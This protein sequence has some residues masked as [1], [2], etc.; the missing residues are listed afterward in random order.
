MAL[1]IPNE[2][3]WLDPSEEPYGASL[4]EVEDMFVKR[5][6][7]PEPRLRRLDALSL[8]MSLLYEAGGPAPIW[9]SGEFI[10]H[11]PDVVPAV[12]LVYLCADTDHLMQM[13]NQDG[14]YQLLTLRTV[15][16]ELPAMV[17]ID[18]LKPVGGLIDA[19]LTS[20]SRRI[21]WATR[22]SMITQPDGTTMPGTRKGFVEVT[23]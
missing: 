4:D 9:L 18:E 20:P 1:P 6:P 3:G 13:L 22:S 23:L 7:N 15:F 11:R 21:F 5:A 19:H 8:H 17:S 10:S 14:I 2:Q 16:A 12:D